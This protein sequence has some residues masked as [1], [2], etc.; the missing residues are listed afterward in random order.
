[1]GLCRI[2]DLCRSTQRAV[3]FSHRS[4]ATLAC[5]HTER[6]TFRIRFL[7]DTSGGGGGDEEGGEV[8]HGERLGRQAKRVLAPIGANISRK[9]QLDRRNCEKYLVGGRET[10]RVRP[11]LS[12]CV[13]PVVESQRT[14]VGGGRG[15]EGRRVGA[16]TA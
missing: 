10:G 7:G 13:P 3:S 5:F 12:P 4:L 6:L 8:E 15:R 1:M 9:K 14:L 16:E 11:H 2:S